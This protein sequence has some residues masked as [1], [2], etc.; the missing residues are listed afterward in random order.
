MEDGWKRI[1]REIQEE[2]ANATYKGYISLEITDEDLG[3][4]AQNVWASPTTATLFGSQQP[5]NFDYTTGSI[6]Y[7]GDK[8]VKVEVEAIQSV[9]VGG[10]VSA[11]AEVSTGVN[12]VVCTS[13]I[14]PASS[15]FGGVI[16]LHTTC[17]FE[18]DL[19]DTLDAFIRQTS[20]AGGANVTINRGVYHVK[21]ID[22]L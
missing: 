9:T 16:P 20:E 21:I 22:A 10:G 19:G 14:M 4:L 15:A 2:Q 8:S 5:L 12:S 6:V 7:T 3:I 11:T 18:I 13:G 17:M 1:L